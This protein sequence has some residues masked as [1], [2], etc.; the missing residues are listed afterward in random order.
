MPGPPTPRGSD[1]SK[2]AG[3]PV[4]PNFDTFL[5]P[6][7]SQA[8][9]HKLLKLVYTRKRVLANQSLM[10]W[11]IYT[12]PMPLF[13]LPPVLPNGFLGLQTGYIIVLL[14]SQFSSP[15]ELNHSFL[16]GPIP[17]TTLIVV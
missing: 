3:L 14:G 7:L 1:L 12:P 16:L 4:P 13:S 10:R 11:S 2:T 6:T 15:M 9:R 5:T 17:E 8:R